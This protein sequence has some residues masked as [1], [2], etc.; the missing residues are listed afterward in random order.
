MAMRA[1]S[2]DQNA[3]LAS[4]EMALFCRPLL[5][6]STLRAMLHELE[7]GTSGKGG[8]A[9]GC[10]HVVTEVAANV[11]RVGEQVYM[12]KRPDSPEKVELVMY[13]MRLLLRSLRV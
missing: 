9:D 8:G 5:M 1:V 11:T 12:S 13:V 2:P 6:R 4:D 10:D 3:E 7:L